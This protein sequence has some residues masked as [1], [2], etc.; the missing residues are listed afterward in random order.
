MKTL[1]EMVEEP[2]NQPIYREFVKKM[3]WRG[4]SVTTEWDGSI[5]LFIKGKKKCL[6]NMV[7]FISSKTYT[8]WG[9]NERLKAS[10]EPS[11]QEFLSNL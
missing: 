2:K 4:Y 10:L 1:K 6:K 8:D 7:C 11:I 9:P 5:A 3:G